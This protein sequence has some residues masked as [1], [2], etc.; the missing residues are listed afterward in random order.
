ME[1]NLINQTEDK[2]KKVIASLKS[3][4]TTIRAGKANVGI[5]EKIKVE[6]YGTKLPINQVANVSVPEPK[7]LLIKPWDMSIISDIEKN[8]RNSDL[9]INP[10]ND[11]KSI[12][13]VFPDL[14]EEHRKTLVKSVKKISEDKKIAIRN[15]RRNY[16]DEVKKM[17]K[18]SKISEDDMYEFEEQIQKVTDK[19]IEEID[20]LISTKEHDIMEI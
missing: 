18:E 7:V 15:V 12:R 4:L 2:M 3:E 6:Y 10:I 14:T 5:L 9:G 16:I 1:G 17:K 19:Y 11:G 20:N 8:I 13:L